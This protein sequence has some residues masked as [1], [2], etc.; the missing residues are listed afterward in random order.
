MRITGSRRVSEKLFFEVNCIYLSSDP[1]E[2][3][4]FNR[5]CAEPKHN[6]HGFYYRTDNV[7][8]TMHDKRKVFPLR[9]SLVLFLVYKETAFIIQLGS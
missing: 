2:Q 9:F 6:I 4:G 1:F 5:F 7:F 8:F 3:A